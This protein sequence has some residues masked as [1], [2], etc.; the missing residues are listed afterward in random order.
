MLDKSNDTVSNYNNP[1]QNKNGPR[2]YTI[3]VSTRVLQGKLCINYNLHQNKLNMW[4]SKLKI[5]NYN[6][7]TL[8]LGSYIKI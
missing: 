8:L 5:F 7:I 1:N 4:D 6:T 2:I 3:L